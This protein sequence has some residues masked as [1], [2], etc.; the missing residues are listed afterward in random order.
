MLEQLRRLVSNDPNNRGEGIPPSG[1]GRN[2]NGTS[3]HQPPPM[4]AQ[5]RQQR[6]GSLNRLS[7][8]AVH[9]IAHYN[10]TPHGRMPARMQ[11]S[12]VAPPP[13]VAYGRNGHPIVYDQWVRYSQY[14]LHQQRQYQQHLPV[15]R[16]STS[17]FP[18]LNGGSRM[19]KKTQVSPP[20][21]AAEAFLAGNKQQSGVH[22]RQRLRP[23]RSLD[24]IHPHRVSTKPPLLNENSNGRSSSKKMKDFFHRV[25]QSVSGA[26]FGNSQKLT[27]DRDV[28][29]AEWLLLRPSAVTKTGDSPVRTAATPQRPTTP[30]LAVIRKMF[31]RSPSLGTTPAAVSPVEKRP[32]S[33]AK[34]L[35][36]QFLPN[37]SSLSTSDLST[38]ADAKPSSSIVADVVRRGD[39]DGATISRDLKDSV[40]EDGGEDRSISNINPSLPPH[41]PPPSVSTPPSVLS[42]WKQRSKAMSKKPEA[43]A[44]RIRR[45]NSQLR[46]S[47]H[48]RRS[49]RQ[50]GRKKK[51]RL[52]TSAVSRSSLSSSQIALSGGAKLVSDWTYLP[53]PTTFEPAVEPPSAPIEISTPKTCAKEEESPELGT[54]SV[55]EEA[56]SKEGAAWENDLYQVLVDRPRTRR[57]LPPPMWDPLIFVPPERRRRPSF[58]TPS[59]PSP[60]SETLSIDAVLS[61]QPW[62][63]SS[64][65]RA[66]DKKKEQLLLLE[67]LSFS[68]ASITAST[69]FDP[70]SSLDSHSSSCG[71]IANKQILGKFP[72]QV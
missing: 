40:S 36:Q 12:Y 65:L 3:Y 58:C 33:S 35:F 66:Q 13:V 39:P 29:S 57:L 4:S 7:G 23:S 31:S 63:R 61:H 44:F 30:G 20:D 41:P 1:S 53:L 26:S 52:L 9:P 51:S 69:C 8:Y 45:R 27:S 47:A 72:S 5:Q 56:E 67:R 50:S 68:S 55:K 22:Q 60:E 15:T 16:Q 17:A 18:D 21:L 28:T 32:L 48:K 37:N 43:P 64:K 71:M 6:S 24:S 70:T 54:D 62:I 46:R 10:P 19:T 2:R 11:L 25:R 34:S 49:M 42:Q 59:V 38:K 14:P